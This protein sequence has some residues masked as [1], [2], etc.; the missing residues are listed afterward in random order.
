MLWKMP[1][2]EFPSV[3]GVNTSHVSLP[4][5]LI[6]Q[7]SEWEETKESK[8]IQTMRSATKFALETPPASPDSFAKSSLPQYELRGKGEE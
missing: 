5:L 4:L 2:V 7:T 8:A 3:G 1:H 6:P